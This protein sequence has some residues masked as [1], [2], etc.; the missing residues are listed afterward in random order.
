MRAND[1]VHFASCEASYNLLCLRI[2]EKSRQHLNTNW[3]AS[4]AIAEGVAVLCSEQSCWHQHRCLLAV[5]NAFEHRAHGNFGLSKTNITTDQTIHWHVAFHVGFR[6]FDGFAL[7][8]CLDKWECAFH[9][10]L[11]RRVLRKR[12]ALGRYAALV[13][14][15]EFL[16]DLSDRR[17]NAL[18]GAGKIASTQTMQG[19]RVAAN[20]L[21][22]C[23]NVIG[24]D[25][26][27]V[28]IFVCK[29]QVIALGA[30]DAALNHALV[31]ANTVIV[32]NH[33]VAWLE[34]LK[35]RRGVALGNLDLAMR[36]ASSGEV[37]LG[38]D[39]NFANGK[40]TTKMQ[41][42]NNDWH[43][44]TVFGKH[45]FQA[46]CRTFAFCGNNNMPLIGDEFANSFCSSF[47]VASNWAPTS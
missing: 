2:G 10:V 4:E 32:V 6:Q 19:G 38:D 22:H 21:T 9:F 11:P 14:H 27:L 26:Q 33:V 46:L 36:S 8:G 13:E 39:G 43:I 20:V 7:I 24:W 34:I 44:D 29:Q 35:H 31:F 3:V 47:G 30:T 23:A 28:A 15:H 41:R 17:T 40:R 1:A 5:L 45:I 16:C 42:R 37:G 25:V 18:L 12:V